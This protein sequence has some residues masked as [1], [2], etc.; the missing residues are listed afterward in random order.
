MKKGFTLVE[1]LGVIVLLG[2]LTLVM[3]PIL[4][5]QINK[6]KQ[7]IN[8][9]TSTMIYEAAKDYMNDNQNT[10]PKKENISYCIPLVTLVT[11][12]YLSETIKDENMDNINLSK[13]VKVTTNN[14]YKFELLD[15]CTNNSYEQGNISVPIVTNNTR[16]FYRKT[17]QNF[18]DTLEDYDI[19]ISGIE[20]G[21]NDKP[22]L[23]LEHQKRLKRGCFII[24]AAADAGNTI[25][26]THYMTI[27]D[28]IYEEN[29]L[30]FYEVNNAPS[31]LYRETSKAISESFSKIVYNADIQ[32]YL[33]L[34]DELK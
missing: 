29:G 2:V 4:L 28:P 14:S 27:G 34:F 17:M 10:Y 13:K 19:I 33:D 8:D 15:E 30:Y 11:N 31:I 12:N 5:N 26:G 18:Y 9:A 1:L 32:R 23:S 3:F 6:S 16:I 25:E 24:D 7:G 20:I 22:V 21:P